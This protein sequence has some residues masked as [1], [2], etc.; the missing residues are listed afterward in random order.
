MLTPVRYNL[1]TSSHSCFRPEYL[2]TR[3]QT[4]AKMLRQ[5]FGLASP[6]ASP[7]ASPTAAKKKSDAKTEVAVARQ[8]VKEEEQPVPRKSSTD[9]EKENVMSPLK[10][11]LSA[12][13]LQHRRTKSSGN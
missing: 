3:K 11:V 8:T 6:A 4:Y 5:R 10:S 13:S 12:S 9:A 7:S 1:M 2:N